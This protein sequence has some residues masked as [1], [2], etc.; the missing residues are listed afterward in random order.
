MDPNGSRKLWADIIKNK[1]DSVS[2]HHLD[3][4][5]KTENEITPEYLTKN[6][7]K[8]WNTSNFAKEHKI[9]MKKN[10]L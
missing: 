5:N 10:E 4:H 8:I 7:N 2:M 3:Y 6:T 9:I 1:P